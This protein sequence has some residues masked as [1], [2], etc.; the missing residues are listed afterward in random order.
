M[1]SRSCCSLFLCGALSAIASTV[2]AGTA[3]FPS[4]EP[5]K[6][7]FHCKIVT[8]AQEKRQEPDTWLIQ[9]KGPAGETVRSETG[10]DR[11]DFR[12][13]NLDPGIYSVCIIGNVNRRHCESVDMYPPEGR[14]PF[15]ITRDFGAPD[16]LLNRDDLHKVSLGNLLAPQAAR[17][18]MVRAELARSREQIPEAIQH[19]KEAIR[20]FPEY[21]DAL[22]NLGI[23][24]L[25]N[26]E[27][28]KAMECFSKVTR[29]SPEFY[30]G[31]VNLSSSLLCLSRFEKA[32]EASARAY[33]MLPQE[34][35][36]I[37]YYARSLYY[38]QDYE[39]AR[40]R[41]E[42]L[43]QLDPVNPLYPQLYLAQIALNHRDHAT[44]KKYLTKFL[45]IHPNIPEARQ[46]KRILELIDTIS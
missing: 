11:Q 20:I 8:P 32:F 26:R 40:K 34:P 9:I 19:L 2:F 6:V 22:N 12:F 30:G 35:V 29:L 46:Y 24:Y 36:V 31:W 7:E 42:E 38:V 33:E 3:S 45:R 10:F 28:L 27:Y 21:A 41:F 13:K 37:G 17:D 14:G 44:A 39:T 1:N 4:R 5:V 23:C 43:D 25:H 18:E 16:S 15:K